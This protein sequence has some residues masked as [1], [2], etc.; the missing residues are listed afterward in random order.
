M[1]AS[2]VWQAQV[3]AVHV[4]AEKHARRAR[5]VR[6]SQHRVDAPRQVALVRNAMLAQ[7]AADPPR[8]LGLAGLAVGP[9]TVEEEE[10]GSEEPPRRRDI[11]FQFRRSIYSP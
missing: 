10:E 3:V 8:Q 6:A 2:Q 5:P 1:D 7:P 9:D 11:G 4:R